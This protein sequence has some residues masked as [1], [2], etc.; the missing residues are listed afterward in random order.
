MIKFIAAFLIL[1]GADI[2]LAAEM[3]TTCPNILCEALKNFPEINAWMLV[4]FTSLG[5]ILRGVSDILVFVG[6]KIKNKSA[7]EWGAKLGSAAV[8]SAQI[9][10]WFGGG[11][12]KAILQKKVADELGKQGTS[13]SPK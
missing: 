3:A 6:E 12:S 5:L 1:M 4:I 13:E 11:T 8:W 9:V 10:G 2:A 7:S